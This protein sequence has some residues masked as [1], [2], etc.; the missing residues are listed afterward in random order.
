MLDTVELDA[1]YWY[2]NLRETVRYADAVAG[3]DTVV[4]VS[5]HPILARELGS[6][7]R[8]DGGL[9]RLLDS[10]ARAWARAHRSTGR[11]CSRVGARVG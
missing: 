5:P 3:F 11:R 4:E 2:R 10:V 8:D 6:L 1:A 7:R 9:P